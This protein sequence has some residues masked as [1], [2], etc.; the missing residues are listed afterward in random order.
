MRRRAA[1]LLA[2]TTTACRV[3]PAAE[4]D[5]SPTRAPT[6]AISNLASAEP[7]LADAYGPKPACAEA[8]TLECPVFER[9]VNH[10]FAFSV[11]VPTFFVKK[12]G[13]AD[14][15]GQAFEYG[16]KARIRAWAMYDN[17]PMTVEQL[18]GDWT[19][20]DAISFKMLAMNTWVVRGKEQGRLYYSRS[21]L[22]DGI[23]STL[24]IAYDPELGEALEPVIARM[25]TSLMTLQ[26]LGVRAKAH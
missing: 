18:Y 5:P 25:G 20:R 2:L 3:A 15:R 7:P 12:P 4:S 19:R 26:G 8:G 9:Y 10:R 1:L 6:P 13:D 22:E 11:D 14:G 24:E 21:I 17:P 16:S 23:I